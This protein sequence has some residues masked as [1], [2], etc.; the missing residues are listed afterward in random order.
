MPRKLLLKDDGTFEAVDSGESAE[1]IFRFRDLQK[2]YV[3]RQNFLTVKVTL[4]ADRGGSTVINNRNAQ[5]IFDVNGTPTN[6]GTMDVNG[7]L[8]FVLDPEDTTAIHAAPGTEE[9]RY[10]VLRWT[11]IDDNARE[12]EGS[13][14]YE[15]V[16][17]RP[18]EAAV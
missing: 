9:S 5:S 11:Y 7:V 18:L 17:Y 6:G 2:A 15:L 4:L 8:S 13:A 3:I 16:L 10:L 1:I 14:E 12:H